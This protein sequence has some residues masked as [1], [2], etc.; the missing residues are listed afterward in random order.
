MPIALGFIAG[1]IAAGLA[2]A[3]SGGGALGLI[4]AVL[5]AAAAYI[6]VS[7]LLTPDRTIGGMVAEFAPDGERALEAV[8][9]AKATLGRVRAAGARI[10]DADIRREI[11]EF[12]RGMAALVH[13]VERNPT[14]HD[15]LRRYDGAYGQRVVDL[16]DT[17]AEVEASGGPELVGETRATTVRA[18][19]RVEQAARGEL[20]R[21]VAD[22]RLQLDANASA[23]DQ[24]TAMDGYH[25]PAPAAGKED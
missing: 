17:Y 7:S 3:I 13:Y 20:D 21:A 18:M 5:A 23:I 6:G 8:D 9:R 2:F 15:V 24:L 22:R 12:C 16:L 11:D 14:A 10:R 19:D 25:A 4:L 1:L